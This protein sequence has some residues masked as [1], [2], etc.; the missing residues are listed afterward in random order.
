M[1]PWDDLLARA[2]DEVRLAGEG[3][4]EELAVS[5]AERVR[6]AVAH[7][8]EAPLFEFEDSVPGHVGSH[9]A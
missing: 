2:Q 8:L 1:D 3:R 6:I 9:V 7:R 4:W 5:T